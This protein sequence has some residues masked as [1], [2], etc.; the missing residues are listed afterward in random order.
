MIKQ[1]EVKSLRTL[2]EQEEKTIYE[3]VKSYGYRYW[4]GDCAGCGERGDLRNKKVRGIDFSIP[5]GV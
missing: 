3:M 5:L 2:S 4:G 1:V